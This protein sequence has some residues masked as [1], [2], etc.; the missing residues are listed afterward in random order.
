MVSVMGFADR[1]VCGFS[2]LLMAV[3]T[4]KN[5]KHSSRMRIA[6]FSSS[7]VLGVEGLPTPPDADTLPS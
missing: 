6:R 7:S 1:I 5:K 4:F 2:F 3:K